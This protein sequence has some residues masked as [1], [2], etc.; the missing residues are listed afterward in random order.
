MNSF[1]AGIDIG[2][3]TIKA[4][5][6]NAADGEI[7]WKDYRRHETRQQ[8]TLLDFLRRMEA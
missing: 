3:T 5:V 2:S 1:F 6:A 8:E 7:I 4:V